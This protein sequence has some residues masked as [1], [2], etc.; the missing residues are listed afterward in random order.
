MGFAKR[1]VGAAVLTQIQLSEA[2]GIATFPAGAAAANSVSIAEVLRYCQENVVVGTGTVLPSNTSLYGVLA[3]T[4]GVTTFPAAGLPANGISMAEVLRELYDQMEKG[5]SS[6]GV[7]LT[8]GDVADVFTV[9]GGHI[10]ITALVVEITTA[11][12]A[13]AAL[14]SFESDPTVGASNTDLTEGTAAPDITGA[15]VGDHFYA[16]GGSA[17]VMVKVA[18]GTDLPEGM[19]NNPTVCP[20]GGID[21]KLS[22]SDPTTG[23]AT[24]HMRYHPLGRGVAVT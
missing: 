5:I 19:D 1:G 22:T 24:I 21:L 14:I 2:G 20:A 3:G 18:N 12:S 10:L 11:V 4:S 15:A 17:V 23:A 7:S 16:V 13:N 6:T 8:G 9:A